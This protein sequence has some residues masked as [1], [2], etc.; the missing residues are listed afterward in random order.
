MPIYYSTLAWLGRPVVDARVSF[1]KRRLPWGDVDARGS[2][3][4]QSIPTETQIKELQAAAWTE[5]PLTWTGVIR[6]DCPASEIS[7]RARSL[8]VIRP[9]QWL[10][11]KPHLCHLP[12][13]EPASH[14]FSLRTR[15]RL[16]E[17]EG[18]FRIDISFSLDQAFEMIASWQ[19]ELHRAR[20]IPNCSSPDRM[21]FS[22][23]NELSSR[24][25]GCIC[26]I[27]IRRRSNQEPQG[28]LLLTRDTG[29]C[30]SWHAHSLLST[31]DARRFFGTYLLMAAAIDHLG[32]DPIWWGGQP[33][34]STGSGIFRF[35]QRFSNGKA[36]AH[37]LSID[38]QPERLSAVR[39]V[40]PTYNWLPNYRNPQEELRHQSRCHADRFGGIPPTA[41]IGLLS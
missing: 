15:R 8:E 21:H 34:G 40:Q 10:E 39:A 24:I 18:H 20:T 38:L 11:L 36:P 35:K 26:L 12:Q 41:K 27:T 25:P 23:L 17:A 9:V 2:W 3:P 1:V 30:P 7:Q 32:H 22:Q 13:D 28:A 29:P 19:E 16:A 33:A 31:P 4:Y 6:P 5:L 37:L 14:R